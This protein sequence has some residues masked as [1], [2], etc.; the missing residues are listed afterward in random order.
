[1]SNFWTTEKIIE[2]IRGGLIVS[3]QALPDEPLYGSDIMARLAN[4]A[5][6]GG[7][8]AIRA[9]TPEDVAAIRKVTDLPIIGLWKVV[10]PGF[11][12]YI[13]PRV[14][15]AEA[16]AEAG[17]DVIAIDATSRPHPEGET[18]NYI[19]AVRAATGLPLLADISIYDEGLAAHEA[20][21]DFISTTMSG[22]TPYSPQ[23]VDPDLELVSRLSKHFN[24]IAEGRIATPEQARAALDAGAM[25]VIVGGAITRPLQ[26]TKR[27]A[28]VFDR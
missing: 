4:A 25:A 23:L 17:A 19:K 2:Q 7:A 5:I 18:G 1:M 28:K 10:E 8:K 16:L 26:I 27:F 12:V 3:C 15:Y 24:V 14:Y 13:T 6:L 9:N 20:S 22:Y 11:D 21:A